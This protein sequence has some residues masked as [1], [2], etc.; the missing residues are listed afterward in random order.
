MQTL[1]LQAKIK[2][3]YKTFT[4]GA[5]LF[6]LLLCSFLIEKSELKQNAR[7]VKTT[8]FLQTPDTNMNFHK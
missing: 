6:I 8:T 1:K 3:I 7:V 4:K 2:R 5:N